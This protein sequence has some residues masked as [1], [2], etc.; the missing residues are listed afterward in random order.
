MMYWKDKATLE[1][2]YIYLEEDNGMEGED[3]EEWMEWRSTR[4]DVAGLGYPRHCGEEVL[5]ATLF[6]LECVL[7]NLL[8]STSQEFL[9][10]A[11][12]YF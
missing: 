1:G 5:E 12:W 6:I 10:T 3:G 8:I 7:A 4:R 11:C 9:T 2:D